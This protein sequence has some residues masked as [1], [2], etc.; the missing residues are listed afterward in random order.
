MFLS[1]AAF[2]RALPVLRFSVSK[3]SQAE[4]RVG[5]QTG[6][7]SHSQQAHVS[8]CLHKQGLFD[9]QTLPNAVCTCF[10]ACWQCLA[11]PGKPGNLAGV[12]QE[13]PWRG[14]Q[15]SWGEEVGGRKEGV[16][17]RAS[18]ESERV[19][20]PPPTI[21]H[22]QPTPPRHP[23]TSHS[24]IKISS[25]ATNC[26]L[27]EQWHLCLNTNFAK[28]TLCCGLDWFNLNLNF[29]SSGTIY[30]NPFPVSGS[31]CRRLL[32]SLRLLFS[33]MQIQRQSN[34]ILKHTWKKQKHENT[35]LGEHDSDGLHWLVWTCER[36]HWER[37]WKS[38]CSMLS[39]IVRY[40]G[41]WSIS[42]IA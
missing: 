7:Q 23:Q 36:H 10:D 14:A 33:T 37:L 5:F 38:L 6:C 42:G 18:Y 29:N 41:R 20:K 1:E 11:I 24:P 40:C 2:N 28:C 39:G 13:A 34:G 8:A 25:T 3:P 35:H 15:R 17:T 9:K 30:W 4:R 16:E 26:W 32:G 27:Q 31:C 22:L 19:E 21:L 12:T